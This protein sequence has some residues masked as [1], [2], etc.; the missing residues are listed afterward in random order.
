MTDREL[1][2]QFVDSGSQE[3]FAELVRRHLDMV[4]STARRLVRDA[5]VAEDVTQA[6]FILLARK[7]RSIKSNVIVAGWLHEATRLSASTAL[8]GE[9]RRRLHEQRATA[10]L[11]RAGAHISSSSDADESAASWQELAPKIDRAL[12]RLRA[13]DRDA[14]VVRFLQAK[15][16]AET[17]R[18]IGLS[19][20]AAKM[21]V[22]RALDQLRRILLKD[23]HGADHLEQTLGCSAVIGTA[24]PGLMQSSIHTALNGSTRATAASFAIAK[25]T[26]LMMQ[27]AT[28]KTALVAGLIATAGVGVTA[29][30][31]AQQT[32]SP[33]AT[34]VPAAAP[35]TSPPTTPTPALA[36]E[37]TLSKARPVTLELNQASPR[38]AIDALS[39]A[40]GVTLKVWPDTAWDPQFRA[41]NNPV[42]IVTFDEKAQPFWKVMFDLCKIIGAKPAYSMGGDSDSI[43]IMNLNGSSGSPG[44]VFLSRG[45][46]VALS[47]ISR[48]YAVRF[49]PDVQKSESV[50]ANLIL[51]I[52]PRL[53]VLSSS[54]SVWIDKLVDGNGTSIAVPHDSNMDVMNEAFTPHHVEGLTVPLKYDWTRS[55]RIAEMSGHLRIVISADVLT[56]EVPDVLHATGIEKAAAGMKLVIGEIDEG[57]GRLSFRAMVYRDAGTSDEQW[58]MVCESSSKRRVRLVDPTGA[59]VVSFGGG[60]G[61]T[62]Q[63]AL[64]TNYVGSPDFK[65]PLKLVWPIAR[66]S[67]SV[68]L[69]FTFKDLPLP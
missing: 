66:S 56:V 43:T 58:K 14:I 40:A 5:H 3:A 18:I 45:Y 4:C 48:Q 24:P 28:L 17:A 7:S 39:R 50:S 16:T 53:D 67:K 63:I 32:A 10:E 41:P 12:G 9:R 65:R 42:P 20:P 55:K 54:R 49:D 26:N 44:V 25:G 37:S 34:A 38:E 46:A 60:S 30:V 33:P 2:N 35:A 11:T 47:E 21:R 68:D 36:D 57:P 8:R 59:T 15:T 27:W 51:S 61:G 31:L 29:M 62:N 23:G 52:D 6:V 22:R 64:N 69:P 19:E 1:L 13:R